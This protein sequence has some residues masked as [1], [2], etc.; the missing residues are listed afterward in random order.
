MAPE[1]SIKG[2]SLGTASLD[3]YKTIG[4]GIEKGINDG[5]INPV[6]HSEY[7]MENIQKAHQDIIESKG[8]KGKLV[9]K[10]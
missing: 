9:M 6:I 7:D 2:M 4:K 5:W 3:T 10:I 8:A 1:A